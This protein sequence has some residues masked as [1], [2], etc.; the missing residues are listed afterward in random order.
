M[1]NRNEQIKLIFSEAYKKKT[2]RERMEYLDSRCADDADL[3]ADVESL[4]RAHDDVEGFLE[5]MAGRSITVMLASP[6]QGYLGRSRVMVPA[7]VQRMTTRRDG[8]PNI[9]Q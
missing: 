6:W 1:D 8:S 9:V 2:A 7:S 3:R 4:L 5:A